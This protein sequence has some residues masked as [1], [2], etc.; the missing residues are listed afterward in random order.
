MPRK[1]RFSSSSSGGDESQETNAEIPPNNIA[2]Y[3]TRKLIKDLDKIEK[4]QVIEL[5][6]DS[7]PS[8]VE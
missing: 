5:S 4:A 2:S 8:K 6:D 7:E 3:V 1:Y